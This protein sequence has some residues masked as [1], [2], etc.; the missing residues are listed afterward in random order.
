MTD[1]RNLTRIQSFPILSW[2]VAVGL[3]MVLVAAIW[4]RFF[5]LDRVPVY[6]IDEDIYTELSANFA[7]GTHVMFS[8]PYSYMPHPP[9]YFALGGLLTTLLG[10]DIASVRA[11]SALSGVGMVGLL[12][13]LGRKLKSARLGFLMAVS[14]AVAPA[15][16]YWNRVAFGYNLQALWI[17]A[18]LVTA[19]WAVQAKA[20]HTSR[21]LI[22]TAL[23]VAL[24]AVTEVGGVLLLPP[25]LLWG[26]LEIKTRARWWLLSSVALTV[27]AFGLIALWRGRWFWADATLNTGRNQAVVLV[28][29]LGMALLFYCL[30]LVRVALQV[31]F[32]FSQQLLSWCFPLLML[33][34]VLLP[35]SYGAAADGL[36]WLWLGVVGFALIPNQA[37]RRLVW[38]WFGTMLLWAVYLNRPERMLIVLYPL[39]A[40]GF[41][42][43]ACQSWQFYQA[44]GRNWRQHKNSWREHLLSGGLIGGVFVVTTVATAFW[45]FGTTQSSLVAQDMP[46]RTA[47]INWL[48]SHVEPSGL[49]VFSSPLGSRLNSHSATLSQY[50]YAQNVP[51][52]YVLVGERYLPERYLWPMTAAAVQVFALDAQ[53]EYFFDRILQNRPLP[54]AFTNEMLQEFA[55]MAEVTVKI[56]S[57]WSEM[58]I[59]DYHLYLN[60]A[61][62]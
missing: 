8:I 34:M 10:K 15:A 51:H 16:V 21:W 9:V 17:I 61:Q 19:L 2:L 59:G 3:V 30:N 38:L 57:T 12:F 46:S 4:L 40:V 31:L 6:T 11:L 25:L 26:W 23:L 32:K 54:Y 33:A 58:V 13:V 49:V 18:A 53:T 62:L 56:R 5:H 37:M 24:S 22:L 52:P 29:M 50:T 7:N 41:G 36:D 27:F 42:A 43:L 39:L 48:N 44:V 35:P 47:T 28:V 1:N 14:Y 55:S 45:L 20:S 60:P